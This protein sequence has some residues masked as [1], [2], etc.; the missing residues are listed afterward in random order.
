MYS[1]K[2]LPIMNLKPM[3]IIFL[4]FT[5]KITASAQSTLTGKIVDEQN[6]PME[7]ATTML[8]RASDSVLV[9]GAISDSAGIYIL[10]EIEA[11]NYLLSASMIGYEK[12]WSGLITVAASGT[13]NLPQLQLKELVQQLKTVTVEGQKPLIQ[14]HADR[15]VVNVEGSI[16]SAGNTALEILEKSPGVAVDQDGNIS[17]NGK[18]GVTIMIDGKRTYLSSADVA[19]MLRNMVSES[20]DEVEII[21]NPSAKYDAAGN[22]GIINIKTKKGRNKGTNG[23]INLGIGHGRFEKANSGFM[24]N[25]RRNNINLFGNYNYGLNHNFNVMHIERNAVINNEVNFF[26]QRNNRNAIWQGHSY[27]AGIDFFLNKKNTVGLMVNGSFGNSAANTN[28]E[29]L[30]IIKGIGNERTITTLGDLDNQYRNMTVNLNYQRTFDRPGKELTFDADYSNYNGNK[31]NFFNNSFRYFNNRTDSLF[32]LRSEAPS[33]INIWVA[34]LDYS[35]PVGKNKFE[36]GA[37][38]SYVYSDNNAQIEK[39]ENEVEWEVWGKFTNDFLYQENINAVYTNWNREYGKTSVMAGLRAEHIGYSGKSVKEDST[40]EN[41]YVSLFPSIFLKRP[42]NKNHTMGF[43]YS[44][45]VDRPSYQ[46][47]N[48]FF[49]LLDVMTYGKGNPLLQPQFTHQVQLNHTFNK[50]IVT[51]FSYSKTEGP[52]TQVIET[53]GLDAFQTKRNLGTLT[54]WSLNISLPVSIAKWW[55]MQNNL[56][57]YHNKYTGTYLD[58][59][60]DLEQL[61]T[62]I[63]IMN[64]FKLSSRISAELSAFYSSPRLLGPMKINS[65]YRVNAGVQ[66]SFWDKNANL[67]LTATDIFWTQIFSAETIVGENDIKFNARGE[68]RRLNLTFN[69]RF[70]NKEVKPVRRKRGASSAE[71]ERISGSED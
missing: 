17:L 24:Y 58:R 48:P 50:T 64:S 21:T 63:N 5:I 2:T 7:F 71:Q 9:K 44:R 29:A 13:K 53:E 35:F 25:H 15:M 52:M 32:L 4:L 47:L 28:N 60:L 54:N 62:N 56:S 42:I 70:G 66:Y 51:N 45:R 8:V 69:Y 65:M 10:P 61:S 34:K 37:K 67:K 6:K 30:H 57:A 43:S 36:I 11:G 49:Y 38:S 31:S 27:K 59:N 46:D 68:S 55:N 12:A 1:N 18:Q 20:L 40:A 26:D 19:N 22:S 14:Q 33:D 23:S 3:L 16:L 39:Q 41:N